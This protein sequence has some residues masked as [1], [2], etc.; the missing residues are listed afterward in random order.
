VF[1]HRQL[2]AGR[3][4][5]IIIWR[6]KDGQLHDRFRNALSKS[7]EKEELAADGSITDMDYA[8]R[9]NLF[10]YASADKNAYIRQFHPDGRQLTLKAVLQGHTAEVTAIRW[11]ASTHQWVTGSEDKTIRIWP[12]DGLPSQ[13]VIYNE[14]PVWSL[15]IDACNGCILTGSTDRC[16]RVFDLSRE[17][18]LV[19]VNRG[20][21]DAIKSIAH[22]PTRNQYVT[23]S[24]DQ[25]IRIWG[26]YFK[27]GA[28][29]CG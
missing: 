9:H 10:A 28:Y 12:A 15:A 20:H 11:N 24:W 17:D 19:Q 26:S 1:P 23:T 27:R 18:A 5:R 25:T 16:L 3:D 2:S 7:V 13:R 22:I 29:C 6:L 8:H 4:R 14:G 21:T